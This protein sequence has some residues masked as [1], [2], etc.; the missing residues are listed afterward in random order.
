MK[1]EK[2]AKQEAIAVAV[3][4]EPSVNESSLQPDALSASKMT[5]SNLKVPLLNTG[6]I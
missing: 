4:E 2:K 6:E 1:K 3:A 5:D